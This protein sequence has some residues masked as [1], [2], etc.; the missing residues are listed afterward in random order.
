MKVYCKNCIYW[1]DNNNDISVL[2]NCEFE[3]YL[4]EIKHEIL[5]KCKY[6]KRKQR[7]YALK[8]N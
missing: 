8:K 7:M 3:K 4:F 1:K 5:K 6:Y 2:A